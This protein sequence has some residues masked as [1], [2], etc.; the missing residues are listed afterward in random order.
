MFKDDPPGVEAI[1]RRLV[2]A[3]DLEHVTSLD[4]I[5]ALGN[6]LVLTWARIPCPDCRRATVT[7][8]R[9][10]LPAMLE[11]AGLIAADCH[12]LASAA[13]EQPHLH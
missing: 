1:E 3:L 9:D 13:G 11:E 4:A 10:A 7:Q 5:N 2:A 6:L 8:L 12:D